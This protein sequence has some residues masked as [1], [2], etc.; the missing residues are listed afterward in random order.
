MRTIRSRLALL[1]LGL[2][3]VAGGLAATRSYE[4]W[5]H[6]A[7]ARRV[8]DL[9]GTG[10]ALLRA[11]AAWAVER[12]TANGLLG[13]PSAAT[14]AQREALAEAR[15]AGDAAFL[16]GVSGARALGGTQV[17]AVAERAAALLARAQEMRAG[18]DRALMSGEPAPA[19]LRS[20]WFPGMGELILATGHDLALAAEEAVQSAEGR[21]Q[22]GLALRLA[23]WEASEFGGRER[24]SVNGILAAGR[25]MS[26]T[27]LL[28]LGELRGRVLSAWA[29]VEALA[30]ELGPE[31]TQ[32]VAAAKAATFAGRFDELRRAVL[33]AGME[34]TPAYP[35]RPAE[36]FTL[37]SAAMA[38]TLAAQGRV[39]GALTAEAD[40]AWQAALT[41]MALAGAAL[42]LTLALGL[43]SAVFA[44]RHVGRPLSDLAGAMGR[45]AGGDLSVSVV[46][47]GRRDEVGALARAMEVF[48]QASQ[49]RNKLAEE[50]AARQAERQRRAEHLDALLAR[51]QAETADSLRG[52]AAA[53]T[54]LDATAGGLQGAAQDGAARAEAMS[55]ASGQA[56]ASVQTVSASTEELSASI[57]DVARQVA[58]SA[59]VARRAAEDARATDA[60]VTGLTASAQ[61]IGEVVRLITDIAGQT[62]LLAL[63]ATIEAA[64]AG[65]AGKGFAVVAGEVKALASQTAKATEQIG[66]QISAMQAETGGAV[67]A[68]QAIARTI[69]EM[70]AIA[71]Q[72]A[73]AAEEQ[74]A[75]TKEIG[76][77]V[78][79]AADGVREVS[80]HAE[81]VTDGAGHTGAAA[82]QLRAASAE[83]A[84]QAEGLRRQM[85]G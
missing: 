46:G 44:I 45:L 80:H 61:R 70:N 30:A 10:D 75:A 66:T 19:A 9:V 59:A 37:A 79:A 50:A 43:L 39:G 41:Q 38:P 73:A 6:A 84:R 32:A 11:A 21:V 56:S 53:S 24:G 69:E 2:S 54:E 13:N 33:Q 1:A 16:E 4:A 35:L 57:A 25:A 74:A 20:A 31:V 47:A 48:R 29:R 81:G 55:A 52:V 78:I 68:I 18:V 63:N 65:E 28:A 8:A 67:A 64:R 15:R 60:A 76:R 22:H 62:N 23:L 26:G 72:V 49:E 51:F 5:T 27:D 71:G 42:L 85:D 36:W 12:G 7:E 40:T 17:G 3:T 77:A 83:L 34:A 82:T 58:Q 14:A